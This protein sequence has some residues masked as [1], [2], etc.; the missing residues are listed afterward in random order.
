ML[1]E[2][3]IV[4][5]HLRYILVALL[6]RRI[7]T[8]SGKAAFYLLFKWGELDKEHMFMSE[9]ILSFWGRPHVGKASITREAS[10]I[11]ICKFGGET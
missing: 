6:L 10:K 4:Q 1:A 2:F 7:A 9:R 3:Q 11:F 8:L 5:T